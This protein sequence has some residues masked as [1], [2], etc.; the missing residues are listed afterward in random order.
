MTR[1]PKQIVLAAYVGG[2][3]EHTLWEHPDAGSQVDFSTFRRVAE[4]A[5][6]G[7]FDYF[8]LAEG[9]ALRERAGRPFDHDIAG[10]P[11]TLPLLAALAAVTEHI[12]LV[13]TLNATFNEPFELA[14]Q[15]AT[16]DHLSGGRAGWNVVTSFDAFTGA[17]FRRGGFLDRA[18]RYAR[19]EEAVRAVTTLWDTWTSDAVRADAPS[20]EFLADSSTGSFAVSSSQFDVSGRFTVPRSPQGRPVIVQAGVSPQGRDFAASSAD[21]IFSPYHRGPE[22]HEFARDIAARVAAAGRPAGSVRILPSAAVVLGGTAAEAEE[23]ARWIRDQ[24]LTPRTIQVLFEQVWNRDLSGFDVDG[25]VPDLE[26]DLEAPPLIEG[27]ALIHGDRAGTVRAWRALAQERDLTLR[28]L[29][30]TVFDRTEYVGT[31]EQVADRLDEFVQS[32]G[33][34]GVVLGSHLHPGGLDEF[35]DRVV[36]LLQERGSL[37]TEYE[38][39]TLRENLGLEIPARP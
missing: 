5:E 28:G 17:N 14:R 18:D 7:R 31:A 15:I 11:D 4:T 12:G 19:A 2:V 13:G 29:A 26:P 35:V 25:P 33:G 36:P 27:R 10:R 9:L 23:R 39:T 8:F 24:Q 20:G 32:G 38:G 6:R 37:R 30:E 34:D 1:R 21:V 16:L 22:A 3:N